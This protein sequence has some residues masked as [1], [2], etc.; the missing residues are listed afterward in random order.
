MSIHLDTL[1]MAELSKYVKADY[2]LEDLTIEKLKEIKDICEKAS[3][4]PWFIED[5]SEAQHVYKKPKIHIFMDEDTDTEYEFVDT[6][7]P[8]IMSISRQSN[9][10]KCINE[11]DKLFIITASKYMLIIVN[12]LIRLK[13]LKNA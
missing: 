11:N 7:N 9:I 3:S 13:E 8:P 10:S 2:S 4:L 5:T 6:H 12:E 1:M